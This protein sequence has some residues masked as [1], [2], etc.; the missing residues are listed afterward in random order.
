V[1]IFD[2]CYITIERFIT[3]KVSS[4]R[5]WV[6]YVGRDHLHHRLEALF[7][8][9]L[10]TVLFIYLLSI[11]MSLT[12]VVLRH[13][14]TGEA[15]FLLAQAVIIVLLVTILE[16]VGNREADNEEQNVSQDVP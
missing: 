7:H 6:E 12:A 10:Q 11:C 13:V 4:F 1:L 16:R 14:T 5:A 15:L 2:M 9:R 3:G 8:S